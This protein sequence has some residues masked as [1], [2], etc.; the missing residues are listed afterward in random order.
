MNSVSDPWYN[1]THPNTCVIVV[2][3]R[4]ERDNE[5]KKIFVEIRIKISPNLVKNMNPHINN[6]SDYQVR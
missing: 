6:F 1:S 3:E 5:T 2:S 4:E